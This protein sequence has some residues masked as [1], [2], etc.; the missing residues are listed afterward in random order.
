M[1]QFDSD[2]WNTSLSFGT[3]ATAP[4]GFETVP[5]NMVQSM[6]PVNNGDSGW[7]SVFQ[8][9]FK[10]VAGYLVAKDAQQ[11]GTKGPTVVYATQ[12][13]GVATA[14]PSSNGMVLLLVVGAVAVIAL[15]AG[16]K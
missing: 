5:S 12:P 4:R 11:S 8:D 1:A 9:V 6:T 16:G 13:A 14:Q 2:F 15:N 3:E 7:T 10:G